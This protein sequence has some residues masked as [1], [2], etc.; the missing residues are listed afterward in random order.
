[1]THPVT[2]EWCVVINN[3]PSCDVSMFLN[4]CT[5]EF[6]SGDDNADQMRLD[7]ETV[8]ALLKSMDTEYDW[9]MLRGINKFLHMRFETVSLGIDPT[10]RR[11]KIR[12]D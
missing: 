6:S 1:M 9:G 5:Q 10:L 2:L 11:R 12:G 7:Q 8:W 4:H 3:N